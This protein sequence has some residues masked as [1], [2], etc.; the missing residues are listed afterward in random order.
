MLNV[1][2]TLTII[3]ESKKASR[4]YLVEIEWRADGTVGCTKIKDA[5]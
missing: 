4:D 2:F 5:A 1:G 3:N